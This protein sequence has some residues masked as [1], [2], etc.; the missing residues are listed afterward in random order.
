MARTLSLKDA[1]PYEYRFEPERT[2]L[3]IIDVQ[4]DF[5]D[6]AGFGSIQCGSPEIFAGVRAVV[7]RIKPVLDACRMLGLHIVHTREGHRPDLSDLPASK[8]YR[9][10]NSPSGHH[11]LGIGDQGPMGRLLIR[12]EEGHDIVEEVY[13]RP[14]E[15]VIDKSGKGSFWATDLHRKLMG[16]GITHLLF[17]GVT[18]ECCVTTTAREAADRGFECCML[19]DC[20]SG[21]NS[22]FARTSLNMICSYDGLFGFVASS[23]DLLEHCQSYSQIMPSITFPAE[24]QHDLNLTEIRRRYN[25]GNLNPVELV[26]TVLDRIDRIASDHPYVWIHLRRRE[27]LASE[28]SQLIQKFAGQPLPPLYGVPFAVKDNI[29]VAGIPTTAACPSYTYV[30]TETAPTVVRLLEAGA[31]LI[32][33]TNMDQLATGLS[34]CRSPYGNPTSIYGDGR[35]IS[36]GSSSG[37]AVAVASGMVT[38]S[39]G[40][41]TAGSGR[42]P[43]S[44]NGIVGIKPTK[45]TLS[46]RGVVPACRS[47]DTVSVFA[48]SVPDARG[49][50]QILEGYDPDDAYAKPPHGLPLKAMDYRGVAAGGFTF[51]IPPIEALRSCDERFQTLFSQAITRLTSCGGRLLPLSSEDYKPFAEASDLLYAGA[52]VNERIACIGTEFVIANLDSLHATTRELFSRVLSRD[53]KPWDVF[54][55]QTKQVQ[56]MR[57]SQ[58]LFEKIDIIVLPGVP[59]HPTV[60]DME[61]DPLNLNTRLGEFTHFANVLDLCAINLNVAFYDLNGKSMPFGIS[62]IG[63]T[64]MDGR[65]MDIAEYLES[66]PFPGH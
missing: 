64:G 25:G 15:T 29:D 7:E 31:L 16:K 49:I 11:T 65:V 4:K 57:K 20:T 6:P 21:F 59:S 9:Q 2:A 14:G 32:G 58:Q 8:R 53:A 13:P 1:K 56:C 10:M 51:A 19:E 34:G 60:S 38:F 27:D 26:H 50:W 30:P 3:I 66:H 39:L 44:L 5:V 43:A 47:L 61:R 62:L 22:K 24:R 33:K 36:G 28:A 52:L 55:D 42:I 48:T 23:R 63:A 40:T 35:Y 54:A 12:G 46:A 37:S 41:D 17:A 18:T 45:G